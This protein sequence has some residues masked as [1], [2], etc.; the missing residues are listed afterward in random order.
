MEAILSRGDEL[1]LSMKDV[2]YRYLSWL[3]LELDF[4]SLTNVCCDKM[5]VALHMI[6]PNA[7]LEKKLRLIFLCE[8]H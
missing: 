5:V 7:F 8:L 4:H 6:L 2:T 3:L 1:A